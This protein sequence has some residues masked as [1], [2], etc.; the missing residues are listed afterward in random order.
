MVLFPCASRDIAMSTSMHVSIRGRQ[1]ITAASEPLHI[2]DGAAMTLPDCRQAGNSV[3]ISS[4][5]GL[6]Q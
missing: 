6:C 2:G 1:C 5:L 4:K 3:E